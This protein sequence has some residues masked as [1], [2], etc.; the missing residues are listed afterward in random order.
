M[1]SSK[2]TIHLHRVFRA[3]T[4]RVYRAFLDPDAIARWLP[5]Y[6]FL[7]KLHEMNPEVG[8]GYRMSFINFEKSFSHTF[9]ATF[10]ELIPNQRI[11]HSDKFDFGEFPG[12][13]IVT[14][15][16]T[17]VSCG[18]EMRI[19]QEGI[20]DSIPLDMCYLGWQESLEQLARL[21]EH[22]MPDE[23]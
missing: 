11:K 4:E 13:L 1:S 23:Q 14:I 9:T 2:N 19:C 3:P 6:G 7:A 12:E 17:E 22:Q 8:G 5:P 10:L 15:D 20:P 16:L 18:T 21:V